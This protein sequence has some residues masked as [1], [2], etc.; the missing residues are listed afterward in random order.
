MNRAKEILEFGKI[1]EK[2]SECAVSEKVKAQALKL[3]MI[4]N[5]KILKDKIKETT[6]ARKI[7]DSIGMPPIS[8]MQDIEKII[9]EIEIGTMLE[10]EM[11]VLV[12]SFAKGT[13]QMKRYLQRAEYLDLELAFYGRGF[14]LMEELEEEIDRSIRGNQVDSEASPTLRSIRRNIE[15][16]RESMKAKLEHIIQAKKEYL[17]DTYIMNRNGHY[18]IAVKKEYK[19]QVPGQC[20]DTSRTG[21]TVFI[22]PS[23]LGRIQEELALL[24]IEE[25]NEV[26]RILYT[27][28]NDVEAYLSEIKSNMEMMEALDFA[29][30]KGKLSLEMKARKVE[31]GTDRH[32]VIRQGKHP[33]LP[34]NK[35]VPLDFEIG[36]NETGI[37]ITGP[38]TGGKTVALKTVGLLSMMVQ[39]GLHV[40][41]GEGSIFTMNNQIL[42]DIGDGQSIEESLSTFSAHIKSTT[43]ILQLATEDSLILLDEMG[44]GTDPKEG[45]GIAIAILEALRAKGCLFLAT[46]HYPEVKTYALETEG[47]QNACMQFDKET[48]MPLYT[49]KIGEVGESCALYIAEKLGF[50]MNLLDIARTYI[51]DEGSYEE[52]EKVR[53]NKQQISIGQNQSTVETNKRNIALQ[54]S[55]KKDMKEKHIKQSNLDFNEATK[56][57]VSAPKIIREKK[58]KPANKESTFTIGDS[59]LVF[60]QKEKGIVFALENKEGEVGVQIKGRKK[61]INKKRIKLLVP[62]SQ[63]YPEDY[64]FSIIFD[65]V[66]NRKARHNMGRKQT[67]QVAYYESEEEA[68]WGASH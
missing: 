20:L 40:P 4:L 30:A 67:A 8:S 28:T 34:S 2:L 22:E 42:C 56:Q 61:W 36:K 45:M 63:L 46:T 62:A 65:S 18:V 64:D 54:A 32:I 5:E 10:P 66:E 25:S 21:S 13:R 27:L 50:P 17:A 55:K 12:A 26:R 38:N 49:L 58:A 59:V 41:V 44:S 24:E 47:L 35:C 57:S 3:D 33:L 31:I 43:E 7:M 29:F 23:A 53:R 1:L 39:C 60:P 9:K 19:N 52:T 68:R 6:E 16:K 14:Y 11:L 15:L 48:L 51:Y 37:V